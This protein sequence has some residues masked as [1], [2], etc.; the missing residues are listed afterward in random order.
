MFRKKCINSYIVRGIADGPIKVCDL[1]Q[2]RRVPF[3]LHTGYTHPSEACRSDVVVPKP[4]APME[5]VA[6]VTRLIQPR[7]LAAQ[8]SGLITSADRDHSVFPLGSAVHAGQLARS[9]IPASGLLQVGADTVQQSARRLRIVRGTE[10]ECSWRPP[11]VRCAPIEFPCCRDIAIGQPFVTRLHEQF[12]APPT[13]L[14]GERLGRFRPGSDPRASHLQ[15]GR[16]R[17]RGAGAGRKE[18]RCRCDDEHGL[19]LC[20][21]RAL[22]RH[23][24]NRHA[25]SGAVLGWCVDHQPKKASQRHTPR[26]RCNDVALRQGGK[27]WQADDPDPALLGNELRRPDLNWQWCRRGRLSHDHRAHLYRRCGVSAASVRQSEAQPQAKNQAQAQRQSEGEPE[28]QHHRCSA[29]PWGCWVGNQRNRIIATRRQIDV[30]HGT[31]RSLCWVRGRYLPKSGMRPALTV[32]PVTESSGGDEGEE[33]GLTNGRNVV[34]H[35]TVARPRT[36]MR[37][38]TC[39]GRAVIFPPTSHVRENRAGYRSSDAQCSTTLNAEREGR[40]AVVQPYDSP[41]ANCTGRK[42]RRW[43][44]VTP[45]LAMASWCSRVP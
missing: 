20:Q 18:A 30:G 36:F 41:K 24:R 44:G 5:L 28:N 13:P 4:A 38:R 40:A 37:T 33:R 17:G 42:E 14:V 43:W 16:S 27:W 12:G 26:A 1:L 8:A 6:T 45:C 39:D 21:Y 19:R 7:H 11:H 2:Q 25:G 9:C 3:V 10:R 32:V 35:A 29:S 22:R 34:P 15:G 31:L 23:E